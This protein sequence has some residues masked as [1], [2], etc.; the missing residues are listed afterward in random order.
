MRKALAQNPNLLRTLIGM[1]LTLIVLLAYAVY[2]ATI[3]TEYYIYK[4][5]SQEEEL[6]LGEPERYYDDVSD[7][8]TWTWDIELNGVNL[9]WINLSASSLSAGAIISISNAAGIY[10]HPD[11]GDPDAREFSCTDS[12]LK[13]NEH[14]VNSTD[15]TA[16]IYSLTDPNPALRGT[17][18]VYGDS[19]EEATKKASDLINT[20]FEPTNFRITVKENSSRTVNPTVMLTQVN[21][22]LSE[23]NQFEV[24]AATEFM[25]ALAAVIGCF[26]MVLVPSFTVYFA[27]RAKQRKL[28][29]K[30]EA[31]KGALEEE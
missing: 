22:E 17:G 25:W 9:T 27:A 8:T 13:R 15:G 10:S 20:T 31:A 29:L 23:I 19:K 3:S 5:N 28:D 7:S 2:G 30:L 14:L 26:S 12:C 11:L 16:V 18:T 21:E 4:S 1:G 24:D 6:E